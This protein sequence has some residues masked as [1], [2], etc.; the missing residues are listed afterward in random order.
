[1]V[2]APEEKF[3]EMVIEEVAEFPFG[4]HDD[5]MDSMIMA[6]Q[7]FR[8]G[9]FVRLPSDEDDDDLPPQKGDY[10]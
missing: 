6:V 9:G 5:L 7:R 1:M 8:D 2:W 10:Y 3:S 4:D